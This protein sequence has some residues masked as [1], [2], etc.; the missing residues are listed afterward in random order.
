MLRVDASANR[1]GVGTGSPSET[2]HVV[3]TTILGSTGAT[4][5]Y[6]DGAGNG[7]HQ[8]AIV[9]RGTD[10][11]AS[12]R[13][14]GVYYHD[15]ASDIEYFSGTLYAND[16]WAVCRKPS[17][18]SHDDSLA[19]GSNAL[20]MVEGGGDVGIGTS[21]PA[22]KLDVHGAGRIYSAAGDADLRMES[23]ASNVTPFM[24]KNGAGNNRVDFM[25]GGATA[26]VINSSQ[27]VGIGLTSPSYKLHTAGTSYFTDQMRIVGATDVGLVVE[28]TD[29]SSMIALKDNSTGGDYYNGI[30]ADGNELFLKANNNIRVKIASTGTKF[31]ENFGGTD[32]YIHMNPGNGGNRTMTLTG[33]NIGVNINGAGSHTLYLQANGGATTFGGAITV[34]TRLASSSS[35]TTGYGVALTNGAT[36]FLMYNNTNDNI[37]YMRDT[38]N[39]AM[40]QTWG[41]NNV[42]IHKGLI[43]NETGGNYDTRIEGDTDANL[44]SVDAA[45][46]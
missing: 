2:F 12:Y 6:I 43:I 25:T 8:G 31:S 7:Y 18:A 19:Q 42:Q 33:N 39:S 30:G 27:N 29:G 22:Y 3:G 32:D 45:V 11:D 23:G 15:A 14:Q 26:M 36:D 37:L 46:D 38:T 35:I 10:D 1:V 20:L 44:V 17:T 4:K 24:I 9:F 13:G 5:V 41:V 40:I 21:N 28:S 16:A 34:V